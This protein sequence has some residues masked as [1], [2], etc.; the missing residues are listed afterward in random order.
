MASESVEGAGAP[1][2]TVSPELGMPVVANGMQERPNPSSAAPS[3]SRM[4]VA[5]SPNV[6]LHIEEL[7]LHGFA[8]GDRQRIAE[9]LQAELTRLFREQGAPSGWTH[10]GEIPILRVSDLEIRQTMLPDA[11][12]RQIAQRLYQGFRR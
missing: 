10:S 8:H 1:A 6:A 4:P 12:G 5:A 11:I 2:G 9:A 7:A 3:P